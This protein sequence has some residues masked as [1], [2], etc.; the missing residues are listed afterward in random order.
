MGT[1]IKKDR[2]HSLAQRGH[3]E[4]HLSVIRAAIAHAELAVDAETR[5]TLLEALKG[6]EAVLTDALADLPAKKATPD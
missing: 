2:G 5:A 3:L 6:A 1:E 4:D